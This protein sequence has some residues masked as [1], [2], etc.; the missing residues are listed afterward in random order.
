MSATLSTV[1][2]V[3]GAVA[4]LAFAVC[5]TERD[6]QTRATHDERDPRI[7]ALPPDPTDGRD[8]DP[9]LDE[10]GLPGTGPRRDREE[11]M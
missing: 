7:D 3:G 4:L 9:D 11:A 8:Y 10:V 5:V 1:I 2:S 6:E